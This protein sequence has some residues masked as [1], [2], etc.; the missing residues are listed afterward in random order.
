[1]VRIAFRLT[2]PISGHLGRFRRKDLIRNDYLS[3]GEQS[4][5]GYVTSM[6]NVSH[7][8]CAEAEHYE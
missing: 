6:T 4:M 1:M 5:E 7:M 3:L 8:V 2:L